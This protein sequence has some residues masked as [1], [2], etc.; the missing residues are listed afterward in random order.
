MLSWLQA[1][2]SHHD[3]GLALGRWGADA[4]RQHLLASPA[5]HGVQ[6]WKGC[7]EA[8]EMRALVEQHFP[9][10]LEELAGLAEGL[11]LT[12]DE[13]FLWNCRGDLWALAPDGCTTVLASNRLTHNEDGDPGFAGR[14]GLAEVFPDDSPGFVS[15]VYPGSIP[16]HTFAVNESG[17]AM[18][19]NNVRARLAHN[20][21][22]RMVLTRAALGLE[23]P[24]EVTA[25]LQAHPRGG[26]FH[27]G[28]GLAGAAMTHSV[29]FS[30]QAVSS[31]AING[32]IRIV[33][34][35]HATHVAQ[36]GLHQII[37]ASSQHRQIRG[38]AMLAQGAQALD[39]L[40]DQSD[41]GEPIYRN[42]AHD[43]D[44]ENTMATADIDLSDDQPTWT[45]YS[46][47]GE[48]QFRLKGI[49]RL[50]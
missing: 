3:I 1:R 42:S 25:M 29:E 4:C 27:L 14:C 5:W 33:H 47:P 34:A 32:T 2:G 21:I 16:G 49:C 10:I 43:T 38:A 30:A 40:A 50:D 22:P 45:V 48:T 6:S 7:P 24:D 41:V 11:G 18:T 36:A 28:L 13:V 17:L 19:V 26:A 37:T 9:W 20:G 31:K 12:L 39:I 23:T 44:N 46:R 35:N 15:F 8:T